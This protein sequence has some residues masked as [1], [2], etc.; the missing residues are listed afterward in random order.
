[1]N[2]LLLFTVS[3]LL[4]LDEAA[5]VEAE[6][7]M[8]K[9]DDDGEY[10]EEPASDRKTSGSSTCKCGKDVSMGWKE[11]VMKKRSLG[12]QADM[13]LLAKMASYTKVCYAHLKAL[14]GHIGLMM[15]SMKE[16]ELEARLRYIHYVL[17]G[18]KRK[19]ISFFLSF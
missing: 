11:A 17:I 8:E 12:L 18:N 7:E 16:G 15:R 5:I 14:G 19:T 6:R 13:R 3:L 10:V 9:E 4:L 1:M 2:D